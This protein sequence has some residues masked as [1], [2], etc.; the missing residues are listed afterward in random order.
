[1]PI[2]VLTSQGKKSLSKQVLAAF[3]ELFHYL[4]INGDGYWTK[5][6]LAG[7]LQRS[8]SS[9][10]SSSSLTVSDQ[11]F[12]DWLTQYE[13]S[14]ENRSKGLLSRDG[15][16]KGKCDKFY[17]GQYT[18][19]DLIQELVT[20]GFDQKLHYQRGRSMAIS[21]HCAAM[22]STT[23]ST[24]AGSGG[25]MKVPSRSTTQL[26]APVPCVV[27]TMPYDPTIVQEAFIQLIAS[28]GDVKEY[29]NRKFK[30]YTCYLGYCGVSIMA[31]NCHNSMNLDLTIDCSVCETNLMSHRESMNHCERL[32]PGQRVIF[33]HLTTKD[34]TKSWSWTYSSSYVWGR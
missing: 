30:V 24:A 26:S 15:F 2:V 17:Q 7:Y 20:L 4:D 19:Q 22:D 29:D 11:E 6:E 34:P 1:V 12:N 31:E 13:K 28:Q 8:S 23:T 9:S 16:M 3:K 25:S 10:T 21:V 5:Q 18:E 32:A 27:N 14:S 33:H